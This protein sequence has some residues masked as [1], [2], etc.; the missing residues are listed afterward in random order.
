MTV[1]WDVPANETII[2]GVWRV[3]EDIQPGIYRTVPPG[4][5]CYWKRLSGLSG[6]FGD[7]IANDFTENPAQVEIKATDYAFSSDDCGTWSKVE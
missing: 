4:E 2:D 3:G 7:I 5:G 6:E 1:G